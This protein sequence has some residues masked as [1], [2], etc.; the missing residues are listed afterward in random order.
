MTIKCDMSNFLSEGEGLRMNYLL[1]KLERNSGFK[2]PVLLILL[3]P[4]Q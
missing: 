4:V 1:A 2:I 3:T